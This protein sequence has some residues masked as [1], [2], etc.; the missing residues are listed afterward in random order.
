MGNTRTVKLKRVL[1]CGFRIWDLGFRIYNSGFEIWEVGFGIV[2]QDFR[3]A[4]FFFSKVPSTVCLPN[5][6]VKCFAH[7]PATAYPIYAKWFLIGD[8]PAQL[9][10]SKKFP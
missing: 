9:R 10:L 4:P 1:G 2:I 7:F 5:L 3:H 6:V 8:C